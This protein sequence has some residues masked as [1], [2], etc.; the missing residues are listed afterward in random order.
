MKFGDLKTGQRVQL[1]PSIFAF[2]STE[3]DIQYQYFT[4]AEIEAMF[5]HQLPGGT[6]FVYDEED[7][8]EDSC[9][10]VPVGEG[11]STIGMTKVAEI[12]E[13]VYKVLT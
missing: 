2:S 9:C 8:T 12:D 5:S 4:R 1:L 10:L 6:I 11:L 13:A 7:P 3:M